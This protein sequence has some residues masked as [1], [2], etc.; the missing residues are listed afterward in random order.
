MIDVDAYTIA[1]ALHLLGVTVWV[2]GQIVMAALVP[3]LRQAAPEAPK[4]AAQRFAQ[5]TWP[6]FALVIVTGIWNVWNID[7]SSRDTTYHAVFGAKLLLVALS[8][9]AAFV[10]AQPTSTV[11]RAVTGAGSLLAGIGAFFC[12]VL[13]V[14]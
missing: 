4:L 9:V 13:L 10:H 2:G 1:T 7:I 6:M 8:G 3:A 11:V 14:T 5:V 12:G